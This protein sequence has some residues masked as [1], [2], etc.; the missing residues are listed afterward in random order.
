MRYRAQ[1]LR[2]LAAKMSFSTIQSANGWQL[3]GLRASRHMIL[4][5]QNLSILDLGD[6]PENSD[7]EAQN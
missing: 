7:N 5:Y 2:Q 4:V 1:C 3:Y 6:N